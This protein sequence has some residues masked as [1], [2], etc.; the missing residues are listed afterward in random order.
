MSRKFLFV[1]LCLL[2]FAGAASAQIAFTQDVSGSLA[3]TQTDIDGDGG[4]TAAIGQLGGSSSLAGDI[5]IQSLTELATDP[6][7]PSV[8]CLPGEFEF[9]FV[10]A[11]AVERFTGLGAL[12]YL[13]L[14]PALGG[15]SCADPLTGTL[16][17]T[18]NLLIIG[19]TGPASG[20]T[21]T[22]VFDFS[23]A[24]VGV[25]S[26]GGAVHTAIEGTLTGTLIP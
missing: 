16:T 26:L 8:N 12:I 22:A 11:S 19:G 6:I 20:A 9:P 3:T 15:Y 2:L 14:D 23:G 7:V 1:P 13:V 18:A 17:G 10:H 21:G 4:T 5:T 24:T 25:D